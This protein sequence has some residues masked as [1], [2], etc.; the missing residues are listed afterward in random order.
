[1]ARTRSAG[2]LTASNTA[3]QDALTGNSWTQ[4]ANEVDT[5]VGQMTVQEPSSTDCAGSGFSAMSGVVYLDGNPVGTLGAFSSNRGQTQTLPLSF[6]VP[7]LFEPGTAI[8]HVLT[9][10][11]QDNCTGSA[12]FV[13]QRVAIDVEAA[14]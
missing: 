8:G 5:F 13:L 6:S 9:I 14:H 11:V 1:V 12:H 4:A 3:Q 2:A 10:Q 7:N